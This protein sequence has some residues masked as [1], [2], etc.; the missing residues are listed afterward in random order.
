QG[1]DL[2]AFVVFS[3][4][5]G[6]LGSAGQGSYAAGNAFLDA[7]V[8]YRRDRGLPGVSLAWGPWDQP[9][10]MVG[11]LS[12]ADR[13][14]MHRS[15]FPPL[16]TEQGVALFDATVGAEDPVMFPVRLDLSALR[17]RGEVPPLLRGLIRTR[18]TAGRIVSTGL[19]QREV[20]LDLVRNQVAAVLGHESATV[21][22][23]AHAFRDLGF[24]SLMGVELRDGL[25]A[26]TGL[27][28]PAT[29]VFDYPTAQALVEH[30]FDE[31][32]GSDT[33][34]SP[35]VAALPSVADDPVVI[36]GMACRYPGGVSSPEQLWQLVMAGAD[37]IGDFPA[38]RGWDLG[39]LYHPD[40]GHP[41]TSSTHSGGFLQDPGE[42][43]AAF[44]G[45]SPREALATDA[46][47]RLLLETVWE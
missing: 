9:D 31:L 4:A 46:Q 11:E 34:V 7:L 15:G 38:D 8:R 40:P 1:M 32:V 39:R 12:A 20:L 41:G 19:V 28:L 25:S 16:S 43:D 35:P 3:S 47:Q 6:T 14:R 45:M 5:A 44:F 21:V 36:V 30:L 23:P 33:G 2:S 42:F 29:L 37:A 17:A 13:E 10:G 26:A 24:D 18:R 22:D 27:R